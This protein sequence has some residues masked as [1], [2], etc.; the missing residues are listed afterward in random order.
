[1]KVYILC[2]ILYTYYKNR[3]NLIH[4]LIQI[5]IAS[6]C[7]LSVCSDYRTVWFTVKSNY[8]RWYWKLWS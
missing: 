3:D 1:M 8:C 4:F 6:P 2:A 7:S 5:C